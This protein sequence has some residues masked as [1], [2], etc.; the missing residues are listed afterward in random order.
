MKYAAEIL[1]HLEFAVR[2]DAAKGGCGLRSTIEVA[3]RLGVGVAV[4]RRALAE[5]HAKGKVDWYGAIE[6]CGAVHF[7][8]IATGDDD[9]GEGEPIP[10]ND[11]RPAL[12]ATA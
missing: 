4:A 8:G 5:L 10:V 11:N 3:D 9:P 12:L 1:D 7:W 6:G 2:R